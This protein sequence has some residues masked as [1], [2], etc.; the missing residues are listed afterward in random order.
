MPLKT[1]LISSGVIVGATLRTYTLVESLSCILQS[2]GTDPGGWISV[3][4]SISKVV[5][6]S[7]NGGKFG[8]SNAYIRVLETFFTLK[9][10]CVYNSN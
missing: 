3:R 1:A 5:F 9:Q 7:S 2:S 10:Y 8:E 6:A 4:G